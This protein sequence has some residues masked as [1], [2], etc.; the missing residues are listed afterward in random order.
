MPTS[1]TNFKAEFEQLLLQF[2]WRQWS[3]LGVSGYSES[4][5]PWCIDPEALLL[6]STVIARKDPRL[7]DEIF[8]WLNQNASWL[9]LQRIN[10]MRKTYPGLGDRSVLAALASHLC[11]QSEHR[12]WGT[13]CNKGLSKRIDFQKPTGQPAPLFQGVPH[14]GASD[15]DFLEWGFLRAPV[16]HRGLSTPPNCNQPS[17]FLFKLRSLFGRQARAEV[18]AWLL[19][20]EAAHPAEIARQTGYFARSVQIV[21]N[22]LELSGHIKSSRSGREK[23]FSLRHADWQFLLAK[24]ERMLDQPKFP[25]WILWPEI[26][27]TLQSFAQLM[28]DPKLANMSESL[29]AIQIKKALQ[30]IATSRSSIRNSF[31]F[32]SSSTG[33]DFLDD[34]L[35]QLRQLLG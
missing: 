10:H 6:F 2:L 12:K 1:L 31:D 16:E 30:A 15:P 19:T 32:D 4:E 13:L 24:N 8:D 21:L 20:N 26:F 5:D 14:F 3:A 34:S 22:E 33:A 7:F 17:T 25:Q 9:N 29:Q 35:E 28:D 27:E 11:R 23:H 18:M